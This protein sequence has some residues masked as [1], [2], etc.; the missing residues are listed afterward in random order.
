M[1][2]L[3]TLKDCLYVSKFL[4]TTLNLFLGASAFS[5]KRRFN[6]ISVNFCFWHRTD[7]RFERI[8]DEQNVGDGQ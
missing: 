1:R 2:D 7:L 6:Q 5:E 3:V 4:R 8:A